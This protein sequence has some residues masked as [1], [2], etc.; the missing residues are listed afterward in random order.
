M[1][2]LDNSTVTVD[3]VLTKKGREILS[4]G[5]DMFKISRFALCDDEVDYSLWNPLHPS[6]SDY[7]GK[8]IENM[9]V[10]EALIDES[11]A[12][13]Y[14]LISIPD[15]V[16]TATTVQLPFIA[17]SS[18]GVLG[19]LVSGQTAYLEV[20]ATSRQ[21]LFTP[22]TDY[23]VNGV[24]Q[25]ANLDLVNTSERFGY[26]FIINKSASDII[27][28]SYG[29]ISS[30]L[31]RHF[32]GIDSNLI[33]ATTQAFSGDGDY[34]AITRVGSALQIILNPASSIQTGQ[35]DMTFTLPITIIGN[36]SGAMFNL[37]LSIDVADNA[38]YLVPTS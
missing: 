2:Y 21:V 9:P 1:A 26:T 32:V 23:I 10:I 17:L 36:Q 37:I 18:D 29:A 12:M 30:D 33:T 8:V 11:Q 38:K 19:T 34:T 22:R 31:T 25:P 5:S 16:S 35:K 20:I 28:Y 14:K 13:R 27:T 7:Y 3:A 15:I 24:E 6:G 4:K